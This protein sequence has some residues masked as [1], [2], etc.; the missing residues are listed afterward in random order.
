MENCIL[1]LFQIVKV[2]NT[3]VALKQSYK[4]TQNGRQDST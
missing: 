3:D 2:Y 1:T 4:L